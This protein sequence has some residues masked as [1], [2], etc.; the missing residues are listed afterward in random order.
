MAFQR[1]LRK[2]RVLAGKVFAR[3]QRAQRRIAWLRKNSK[4]AMGITDHKAL[5]EL[6]QL[7]GFKPEKFKNVELYLTRKGQVFISFGPSERKEVILLKGKETAHIVKNI[8][9]WNETLM[10]R[11]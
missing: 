1:S 11:Q 7:L 10:Q 8:R 9:E 3:R 5:T 4:R 2:V 6:G